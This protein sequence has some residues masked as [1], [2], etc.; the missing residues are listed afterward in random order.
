EAGQRAHSKRSIH[1]DLQPTSLR[2]A[3]VDG[4]PVVKVIE[5]GVA[6]AIGQE[7]T[8]KTIYTRFN[9]M[10]GTPLYMSPEQ[11]EVNALD[12][13]IRSD[14]Y[15]LGVLLYELLTGTTPFDRQ[16][17]AEAAYDEIRRI[18]REE[19]PPKPSTRF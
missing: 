3:P 12:V 10:I 15:S 4:V 13:D 6:K 9:Q 5:F 17:F 7:L 8:D 18:I 19:E 2:V 1:R 11:A 14:V 16:R